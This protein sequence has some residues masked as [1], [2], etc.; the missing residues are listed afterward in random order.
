MDIP[1]VTIVTPSFNQGN[2]IEET[3]LSIQKQSYPNIEHIIVDGGSNDNTIDIIKKYE[4][5][6]NMRWI[7]EPD[8]GQSDA[9]NKGFKMVGGSIVGWLNSD[10]VYFSSSTISEV[11]KAF[12]ENPSCHV[13][14]GDDVLIDENSKFLFKRTMTEFNYNKMLTSNKIS[15]PATFFLKEAISTNLLDE[16]LHYAM[17]YELWLRLFSKGYKFRYLSQILACNRI[18]KN[19]KMLVGKSNAELEVRIILENLSIA[20]RNRSGVAAKVLNRIKNYYTRLLGIRSLWS[21]DFNRHGFVGM[22]RETKFNLLY[23][24]IF[25]A[26]YKRAVRG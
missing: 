16:S 14:F 24:Q 7:S 4:N 13:V 22:V 21:I 25:M 2:F 23:E 10:D 5:Q 19:R 9:I 11:V 20:D 26:N 6:Y 18:H 3:I 17:D 8:N 15:Q 1:M 12:T